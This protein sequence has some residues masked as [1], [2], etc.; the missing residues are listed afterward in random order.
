MGRRAAVRVTID[1]PREE[2][3]RRAREAWKRKHGTPFPGLREWIRTLI[4][5]QYGKEQ[6]RD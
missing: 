3:E 5:E 6:A 1:L 2:V 4:R